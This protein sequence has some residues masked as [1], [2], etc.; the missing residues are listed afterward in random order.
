[1]NRIMHHYQTKNFTFEELDAISR[2][3]KN[4]GAFAIHYSENCQGL[5]TTEGKSIKFHMDGE[6]PDMCITALF[7]TEGLR[8]KMNFSGM[9]EEDL[10][11]RNFDLAF[12][13]V[14]VDAFADNEIDLAKLSGRFV[15]SGDANRELELFGSSP[16]SK[17]E[18]TL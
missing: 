16:L 18:T 6:N 17:C 5:V 2:E 1:M 13:A 9:S 14:V 15:I 4:D 3:H 11:Q 10:K 7:V 8:F 12:A